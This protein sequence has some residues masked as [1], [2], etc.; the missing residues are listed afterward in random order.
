MGQAE[1]AEGKVEE[2][3]PENKLAAQHPTNTIYS[4]T[5]NVGSL[6]SD[7]AAVQTQGAEVLLENACGGQECSLQQQ[8]EGR[9]RL[10]DKT[11]IT[12]EHATSQLCVRC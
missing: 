9:R 6:P 7:E 4:K 3:P 12:V 8:D 2:G 1:V 5:S 10:G 11:C